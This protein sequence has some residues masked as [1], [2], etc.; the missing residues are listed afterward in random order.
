MLLTSLSSYMSTHFISLPV[1]DIRGD[2]KS[3]ALS[4]EQSWKHGELPVGG[5]F[6]ANLYLN[7]AVLKAHGSVHMDATCP[8][9]VLHHFL[10]ALMATSNCLVKLK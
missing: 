9:K 10:I 2:T 3:V 6:T 1:F 7:G 5:G 4:S 8:H